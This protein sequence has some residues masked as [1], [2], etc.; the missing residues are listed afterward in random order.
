MGT[1]AWLLPLGVL[2]VLAVRFFWKAGA[3]LPYYVAGAAGCAILL[4]VALRDVVPGEDL[5]RVATAEAVHRVS[6]L[7]GVRT[8]LGSSE[9]GDLMVVGVPHNNEWTLLSIGIECSGLLEMAALFGLVA[10][11]PA[12]PAAKRIR[13]LLIAL[14]LTF[15]AN[16]VRMLVIVAAVGYGGQDALDIAHVVFGRAVF[17]FL[18]IAIYWF[19]ITKPTLTTVGARLREAR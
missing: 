4:V 5:I 10:F 9:A 18:A 15:V 3:W 16:I 11:F 19:A 2:W 14:G 1:L 13:V 6:W 17:F 7:L 12:L 8:T